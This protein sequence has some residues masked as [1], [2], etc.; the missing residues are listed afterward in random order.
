M[1]PFLPVIRPAGWRYVLDALRFDQFDD[2]R[3]NAVD[4][5]ADFLLRQ[6]QCALLDLPFSGGHIPPYFRVGATAQKFRG[7]CVAD[8][9]SVQRGMGDVSSVIAVSSPSRFDTST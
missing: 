6:A 1:L 7:F 8:L 3:L 4:D 2:L 9:L 5:S